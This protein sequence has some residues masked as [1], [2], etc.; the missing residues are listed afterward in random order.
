LRPRRPEEEQILVW[1]GVIAQL[2]RTRV[3]Q[4]LG[5]TNLPYPQFVLLLHFCHDPKRE[6]TVSSLAD[7][8]QTNQPGITKTVKKL[9]ER[10]YLSVRPDARDA[11]VRRLRVTKS[12]IRARN[13]A[14]ARMGPD[15]AEAFQSWK[16]SDISTLHRQLERLK[17]Y[18]DE[19]RL[20]RAEPS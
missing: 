7:A 11:R 5:E 20:P 6:W 16:R 3:N 12:G 9:I 19:N 4:L 1:I 18:L 13:Q 8:F 14:I 10:R 15:L 2:T 17:S